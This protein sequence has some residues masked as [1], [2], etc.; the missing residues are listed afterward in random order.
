LLPERGEM[1]KLK[2]PLRAF[3]Q[4]N[5]IVLNLRKMQRAKW[6]RFEPIV[7]NA[8]LCEMNKTTISRVVI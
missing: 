7:E 4:V 1:R 6:V 3:F 8:S 5:N 2:H